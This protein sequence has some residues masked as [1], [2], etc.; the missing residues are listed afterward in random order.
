MLSFPVVFV[1]S[2]RESDRNRINM[3]KRGGKGWKRGL[4]NLDR[5]KNRISLFFIESPDFFSWVSRFSFIRGWQV[6]VYVRIVVAAIFDFMTEED[7]ESRNIGEL[8]NE[9]K[10]SRARRKRLP[11]SKQC[12]LICV[13]SPFWMTCK[14]ALAQKAWELSRSHAAYIFV[15][16]F[17]QIVYILQKFT[18][19]IRLFSIKG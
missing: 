17:W 2:A 12:R 9:Q 16:L 11:C 3:A 19:D 15:F 8:N 13:A 10:H 4:F 18:R 7:W 6:C 14:H 5:E 1:R